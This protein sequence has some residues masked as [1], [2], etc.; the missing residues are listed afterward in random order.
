M[1]SE[2]SLRLVQAAQGWRQH[3]IQV[4][5]LAEGRV[6]VKGQRAPRA[7]WRYTPLNWLAKAVDLPLLMAVPAP[8]GAEGQAIEVRRLRALEE[9]GIP[10]PPLLHVAHD[11]MVLGFV[12]GPALPKLLAADSEQAGYAFNLALASLADVH[13]RGQYLS[14]AFARNAILSEDGLVYLDFEDD[15]RS[16]M[17]LPDAQARDWLTLLLSSVWICQ[18]DR[19]S[20]L[21]TWRAREA[22]LSADVRDRLRRATRRLAWLRR[23]PRHRRPWG[24]DIVSIQALASFLYDWERS[25]S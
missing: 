20:M 15:P 18:A 24:R 19:A 1:L 6:V 25:S 23:L 8:G 3:R 21:A 7:A 12:S 5:D 9:A 14:Q 11:H 22:T 10:V 4:M 17:S 16:V 2:A 13:R